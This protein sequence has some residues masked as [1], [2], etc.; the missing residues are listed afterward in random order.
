M[1]GIDD[2]SGGFVEN[3]P[4]RV[5]FRQ[6]SVVDADWVANRWRDGEYDY[7]YHLAAYAAEGLCH[8]IRRFNYQTNLIGSINLINASVRH[9]VKCF[10]FTSSIAVYGRNQ[11]PMTEN[12]IPQPEDPYGISKYAVELDLA[13][14]QRLFGLSYVIFRPHNVYG[15]W[16]NIADKYRN[17]IGIFM[18]QVMQKKPMTIF[19]DGSQTRAFTYIDDVV[20]I[21][22]RAPLVPETY[23]Q[24]FNIGVDQPY[25]VRELACETA[26]AFGV[27]PDIIHL[28]P[29]QEVMHAFAAHEKVHRVF[30][31]QTPVPLAEGLIRMAR[32]VSRHGIM[33]PIE[34][35]AIEVPINLPPI[36]I[37]P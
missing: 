18:N 8:F 9:G 4:P 36:W 17:V 1:I 22:T 14:A 33:T 31:S 24:T 7:V 13:A 28:P 19:G 12:M 10:I 29:R 21:I 11:T 5:D 15:E 34:V 25:T 2:L 30:Q 35:E 3:I 32:W 16:Q 26:R 23:Q 37:K 27:E 20:P 6:G